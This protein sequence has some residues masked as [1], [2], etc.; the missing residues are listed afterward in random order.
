MG[1]GMIM[2]DHA[3]RIGEGSRYGRRERHCHQTY[4]E[5]CSDMVQSYYCKFFQVTSTPVMIRHLFALSDKPA[6]VHSDEKVT[7]QKKK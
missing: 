2:N 3:H 1:N 4:N 6:E 7:S 5:Q